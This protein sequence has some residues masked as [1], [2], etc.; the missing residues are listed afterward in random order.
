MKKLWFTGQSFS[1]AAEELSV[2]EKAAQ[3]MLA[4]LKTVHSLSAPTDGALEGLERQRQSQNI[5]GRL[6]SPELGYSWE[7]FQLGSMPMAWARPECGH[8]RHHVV[9]YCHGGGYT[10][11]NLGYAR[12]LASKLAKSTGY[13]VLSFEYRLAPE[14][15]YPAA[16]EDALAAWDYL[17]ELGYGARDVVLAGDSAGGNLALVLTQA[18][19]EAGRRLPGKLGLCSPWTDM[20]CSGDSYEA[21]KEDDPVLTR[22]YLEAVR[23]AYAPQGGWDQPELSPLFQDVSGFPP[24]LVQY[25]GHEILAD[26]AIRLKKHLD[27]AGIPNVL[28]CWPEMWHVFQ[29][30]PLPQSQQAMERVAAFV[31]D[32]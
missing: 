14:H 7:P 21:H 5:L 19:K 13:E 28:Q 12:V 32:Y 31:L 4:A 29:M 8:D 27:E 26:D 11:G 9:L 20:S 22:A 23:Q 2:N 30:F 10:S 17:M 24:V 15:P 18:L 25:G 6:V 16:L 3:A 1:E